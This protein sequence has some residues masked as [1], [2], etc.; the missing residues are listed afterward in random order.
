MLW[1]V[2]AVVLLV[3]AIA[4]GTIVHPLLFALAVLALLMFLVGRRGGAA[5]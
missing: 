3:V 5:Y 2:I 1:L 4:G